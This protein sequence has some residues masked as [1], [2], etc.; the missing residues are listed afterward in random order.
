MLGPE[1]PGELPC[2]VRPSHGVR[3]QSEGSCLKAGKSLTQ[4]PALGHPH[5]GLPASRPM[6]KLV[7]CGLSHLAHGILHAAQ[8][9]TQNKCRSARATHKLF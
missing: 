9:K 4:Q 1:T 2:P 6:T 5:L 8:A 3:A 7:V